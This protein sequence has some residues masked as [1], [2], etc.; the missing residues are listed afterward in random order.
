MYGWKTV[1]YYTCR[2]LQAWY[3]CS[4]TLVTHIIRK[5]CMSMYIQIWNLPAWFYPSHPRYFL[6]PVYRSP[7][8]IHMPRYGRRMVK[9]NIEVSFYANRGIFSTTSAL[10]R[11]PLIITILPV[12]GQPSLAHLTWSVVCVEFWGMHV[13]INSIYTTCLY[14]GVAR[15]LEHT[16]CRTPDGRSRSNGRHISDFADTDLPPTMLQALFRHATNAILY[17]GI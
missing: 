9:W 10:A 1:P 8:Y 15:Q 17:W 3:I 5:I 13:S 16:A 2:I 12:H 14:E 7:N 11:L 6:E 4:M